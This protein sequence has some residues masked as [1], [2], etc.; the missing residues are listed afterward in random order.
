ML[1]KLL[2]WFYWGKLKFAHIIWSMLHWGKFADVDVKEFD[3]W[4]NH[5]LLAS[6]VFFSFR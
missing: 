4:L 3:G 2:V 5:C 1:M 6:N